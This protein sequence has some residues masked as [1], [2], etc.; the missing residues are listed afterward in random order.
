[1]N[2]KQKTIKTPCPLCH[3]SVTVFQPT[4]S[5]LLFLVPHTIPKR[6]A[7]CRGSLM[8]LDLTPKAATR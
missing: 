2:T 3:K 1:M 6:R 4:S 8:H 7:R 5:I